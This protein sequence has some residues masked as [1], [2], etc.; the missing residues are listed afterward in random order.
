MDVQ[1]D[2]S[3][4]DMVTDEEGGQQGM[5]GPEQMEHV[6]LEVKVTPAEEKTL[7][8][9]GLDPAPTL[10]HDSGIGS[11]VGS[12]DVGGS[13]GSSVS[14]SSEAYSQWRSSKTNFGSV[15]SGS[16]EEEVFPE[17]LDVAASKDCGKR[18]SHSGLSFDAENIMTFDEII[19]S[20]RQSK[21]LRRQSNVEGSFTSYCLRD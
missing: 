12:S 19:G 21:E 8:V 10:R 16:M 15:E 6:S 13:T 7:Q 2:S 11:S 17:D 4:N 1:E 14:R 20:R 3:S 5:P 9:E 18:K